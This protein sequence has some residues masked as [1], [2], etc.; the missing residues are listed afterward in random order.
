MTGA[1]FFTINTMVDLWDMLAGNFLL[2]L[3]IVMM[4]IYILIDV[5]TR[6]K[7]ISR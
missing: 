1:I 7:N 6:L 3:P 5:I 4:F 2:C